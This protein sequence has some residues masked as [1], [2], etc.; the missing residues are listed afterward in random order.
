[1]VWGLGLSYVNGRDLSLYSVTRR[2]NQPIP[3]SGCLTSI[4]LL[5]LLVYSTF[6]C[7]T[8]STTWLLLDSLSCLTLALLLVYLIYLSHWLSLSPVW[9]ARLSHS[10]L[11]LLVCLSSS[12][13]LTCL[14]VWLAYLLDLLV[15]LIRFFCLA[16]C[17]RLTHSVYLT[18][19]LLDNLVY[20]LTLSITLTGL[21]DLFSL[22]NYFVC[23][24]TW[25]LLPTRPTGLHHV[26]L[27]R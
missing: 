16:Y 19:S 13:C 22:S 23:L 11:D 21:F 26:C 9:L 3:S 20:R 14:S 17:V 27:T 18:I 5:D 8:S 25:L 6:L 7:A 15:C 4:C 1:M 24:T 12:V 10:L 2:I